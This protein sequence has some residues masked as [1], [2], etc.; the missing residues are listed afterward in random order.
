VYRGKEREKSGLSFNL[1]HL[2][3]LLFWFV[4]LVCDAASLGYTLLGIFSPCR[5]RIGGR[6]FCGLIPS[7]FLG[8]KDL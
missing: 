6:V 3:R 2:V 7:I 1:F 8:G 5:G 4:V